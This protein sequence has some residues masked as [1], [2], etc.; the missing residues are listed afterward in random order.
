MITI[1]KIKMPKGIVGINSPAFDLPIYMNSQSHII[2]G[3]NDQEAIIYPTNWDATSEKGEITLTAAAG[4]NA[5]DTLFDA[6]NSKP[7]SLPIEVRNFVD[8]AYNT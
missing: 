4:V 2:R 8:Y 5:V 7:G 6:I 3:A 1:L